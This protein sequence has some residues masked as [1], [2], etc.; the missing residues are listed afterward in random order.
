M[1]VQVRVCIF[2]DMGLFVKSLMGYVDQIANG[3]C[4]KMYVRTVNIDSL[5]IQ[6]R[7]DLYDLNLT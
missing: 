7:A 5:Q 4:T 6:N 3:Q 2:C 1:S